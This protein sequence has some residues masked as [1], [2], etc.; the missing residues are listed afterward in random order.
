L[1]SYAFRV[2]Q[3]SA[4]SVVNLPKVEDFGVKNEPILSNWY[5]LQLNMVSYLS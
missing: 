4:S 5:L 2:A 1:F 3:R